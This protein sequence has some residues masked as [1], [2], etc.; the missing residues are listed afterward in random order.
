MIDLVREGARSILVAGCETDRC[1]FG[2]GA[3]LAI[4]QVDAAR[5]MLN[6]L[7]HDADRIVTHWSASRAFDRL[8]GQIASLLD[9]VHE[10][11]A[12]TKS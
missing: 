9:A 11:T 10:S 3:R 2:D 1:R 5:R 6:V 4:E 7:G 12:S 8:D